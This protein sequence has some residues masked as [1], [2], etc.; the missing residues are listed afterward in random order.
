MVHVREM[1]GERHETILQSLL[2]H[3]RLRGD[4]IIDYTAA[5]CAPHTL[6]EHVD[7][8]TPIAPR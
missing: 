1:F 5:K 6:H 3:G 8:S 7:E 4:Q 2:E